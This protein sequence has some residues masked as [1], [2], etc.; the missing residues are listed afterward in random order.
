MNFSSLITHAAETEGDIELRWKSS[1]MYED[2]DP[3]QV[4]WSGEVAGKARTTLSFPPLERTSREPLLQSSLLT[5]RPLRK[6]S[7]QT[8]TGRLYFQAYSVSLKTS[9]VAPWGPYLAQRDAA[10]G[11]GVL[12]DPERVAGTSEQI[13]P[14]VVDVA[15][16][17]LALVGSVPA[18]PPA[19]TGD[20][21]M[22][23][24]TEYSGSGGAATIRISGASS[25]QYDADGGLQYAHGSIDAA[26]Q[27]SLP[28]STFTHPI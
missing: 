5:L 22:E 4:I 15:D 10:A 6:F 1:Y 28:A 18:A 26:V 24:V 13:A 17:S 21:V 14:P 9:R 12:C 11:Q 8:A 2:T 25:W 20:V 23:A 27:V 16:A 3:K 7:R 19:I